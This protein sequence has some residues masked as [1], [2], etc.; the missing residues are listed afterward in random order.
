MSGAGLH[1]YAQVSLILFLLAFLIV[2]ARLFSRRNDAA[3]RRAARLPLED[4]TSSFS[5]PD[6]E[7]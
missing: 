3:F 1:M 7:N 5:P 2:V 4:D 6:V